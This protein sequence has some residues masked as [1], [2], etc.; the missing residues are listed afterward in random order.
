M[1]IE[2]F[3]HFCNS[4]EHVSDSFP[5]DHKTL[6]FKVYS[7]IFALCDVDNFKSVNLKCD[8]ERA[9]YLRENYSSI[10]PGYHMN[11][12]H[13]NTIEINGDVE[14]DLLKEL[15]VHSFELVLKSVSKK[16]KM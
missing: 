15:I 16:E 3:H 10:L 9:I 14:D 7:K 13:W 6:V 5:F 11:K 12:K 8:P 4:L 2:E 1:N